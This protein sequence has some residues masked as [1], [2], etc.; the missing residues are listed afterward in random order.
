MWSASFQ[1]FNP[2][3][4]SSTYSMYWWWYCTVYIAP[5]ITDL[6]YHRIVHVRELIFL[7][8]SSPLPLGNI[9]I[10]MML[11]VVRLTYFPWQKEQKPADNNNFVK[12]NKEAEGARTWKS[13]W[14][15]KKNSK[16]TIIKKEKKKTDK[17]LLLIPLATVLLSSLIS[18]CPDDS[19]EKRNSCWSIQMLNIA[20]LPTQSI[21]LPDCRTRFSSS[22]ASI[23]RFYFKNTRKKKK[24]KK[25]IIREKH[26]RVA[27][28]HYTDCYVFLFFPFWTHCTYC[29]AARA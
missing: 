2:H 18:G 13:Q 26:K 3:S 10:R 8:S 11:E 6:R 22:S 25:R 9:D 14:R 17:K 15:R 23:V 1:A 16:T 29:P 4:F 19:F 28:R 5:I 20:P 21:S 12:E 24:K 27:E 7:C